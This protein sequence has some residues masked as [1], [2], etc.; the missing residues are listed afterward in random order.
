MRAEQVYLLCRAVAK[1]RHYVVLPQ[2]CGACG[3]CLLKVIFSVPQNPQSPQSPHSFSCRLEQAKQ[4][5]TLRAAHPNFLSEGVRC[6][7]RRISRRWAV[8]GRTTH[9]RDNSLAE[10]DDPL[11]QEISCQTGVRLG[12]DKEK[13][14][15]GCTWRTAHSLF[16]LRGRE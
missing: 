14:R 12:L 1:S 2:K 15:M 13:E 5:Q 3:A 8:L 7:A 16:G 11:S 9:W 6:N 4:T 10:V